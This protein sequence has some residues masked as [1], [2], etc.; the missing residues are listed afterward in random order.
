MTR[1]ATQDERFD[2][3]HDHRKNW[4]DPDP[5]PLR[6]QPVVPAAME[7]LLIVKGLTDYNAAANLIE[8]YAQTV[9]SQARLQAVADTADRVFATLDSF[10]VPNV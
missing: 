1:A 8:A 3:A 6:L 4:I 5:L 9:A 2:R 7:V 10:K